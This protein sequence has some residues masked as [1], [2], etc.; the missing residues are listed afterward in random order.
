MS[1]GTSLTERF[2]TFLDKMRMMRMMRK[3]RMIRMMR[4]VKDD[5]EDDYQGLVTVCCLGRSAPC[6]NF[7]LSL[8]RRKRD[9]SSYRGP[10]TMCLVIMMVMVMSVMVIMMRV[11]M[12]SNKQG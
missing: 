3:M 5:E 2:E 10:T 4:M 7:P 8:Q 12:M 11:M 9:S 6:K 1:R